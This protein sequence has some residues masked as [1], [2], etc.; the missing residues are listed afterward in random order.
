MFCNH[1]YLSEFPNPRWLDYS[2]RVY[3][4]EKQWEELLA[5]QQEQI[6]LLTKLLATK[7]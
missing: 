2:D 6:K 1:V 7:G 3:I 4:D 5:M